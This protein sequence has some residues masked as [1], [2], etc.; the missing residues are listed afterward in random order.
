MIELGADNVVIL[1]LINQQMMIMNK[2]SFE[3]QEMEKQHLP[4]L[5][6]CCFHLECFSVRLKLR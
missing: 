4:P 5:G 6:R 2:H 3:I 1:L